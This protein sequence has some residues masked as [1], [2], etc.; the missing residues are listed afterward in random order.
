MCPGA[1]AA[2]AS[3]EDVSKKNPKKNPAP[4]KGHRLHSLRNPDAFLSPGRLES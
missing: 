2:H 4:T 1:P 3:E